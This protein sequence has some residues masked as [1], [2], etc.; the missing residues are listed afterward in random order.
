MGGH[1]HTDRLLRDAAGSVHHDR[2]C[3]A[4]E[5]SN[6]GWRARAVDV[7]AALHRH[8]VGCRRGPLRSLAVVLDL[9]D[10]IVTGARDDVS[11]VR[12]QRCRP[13][14]GHG[15]QPHRLLPEPS[16]DSGLNRRPGP[17]ALVDAV[18]DRV[19]R[20]LAKSAEA[21]A[22][23]SSRLGPFRGPHRAAGNCSEGGRLVRS[24][25][26]AR[27]AGDDREVEAG[28][29]P[30]ELRT[31]IRLGRRHFALESVPQGAPH[32]VAHERW[33]RCGERVL[34]TFIVYHRICRGELPSHRCEGEGCGRNGALHLVPQELGFLMR[35][36]AF[37]RPC[38]ERPFDKRLET[39]P[40][41]FPPGPDVR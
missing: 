21:V 24:E 20:H 41:G 33:R 19:F 12:D 2:E 23:I 17:W 38:Y 40:S 22:D 26:L 16:G 14:W 6:D 28:S 30:H 13:E 8:A 10:Q 11:G 15:P 34:D 27:S 1:G 7:G 36:G 9:R 39:G 35:D 32:K 3:R 5:P 37:R 4:G 31:V 25:L 29:S 18:A